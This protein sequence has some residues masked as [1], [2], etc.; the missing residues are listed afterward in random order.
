MR[1]KQSICMSGSR[2]LFWNKFHVDV[3]AIAKVRRPY[4]SSWN[5]G[6][7]SRWRLAELRCCRSATWAAGVHSSDRLSGALPCKH[8]Y[9]VTSSL[10]VTRSATSSQCS[11]EW[12]RCVKPQSYFFVP[13]TTRASLVRKTWKC[14]GIWQLSGKCQGFYEKSGKCQ[15]KKLVKEKLPK[16]IYCQLHI[17]T[18]VQKK[19]ANFGGL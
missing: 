3:P 6:T 10:Y 1:R 16:T 12:S 2:K 7:T 11:S 13:L 17:Y 15:G 19:R 14:H 5:R 4:V 18:V 8:L 9:T